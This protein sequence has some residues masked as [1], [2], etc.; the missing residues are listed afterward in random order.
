M[1]GDITQQED[2]KTEL[3]AGIYMLEDIK[4]FKARMVVRHLVKVD[5]GIE[6]ALKC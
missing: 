2:K 4:H 6:N 5:E 3:R 1:Y